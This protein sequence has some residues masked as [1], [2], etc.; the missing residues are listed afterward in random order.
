MPLSWAAA[1]A[2]ASGMA[3][4]KSSLTGRPSLGI[5]NDSGVAGEGRRKDFDRD[6]ATEA[7]IACAIDLPH[8]AAAE[9]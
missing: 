8:A 6:V 5:A 4:V 1:T 3:M 7:G 2:S 9:Q